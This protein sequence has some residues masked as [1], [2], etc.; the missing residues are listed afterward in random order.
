MTKTYQ[1]PSD[2]P[3][4][5]GPIEDIRP[6]DVIEHH[7]IDEYRAFMRAHKGIPDAK[8]WGLNEEWVD[9]K[10]RPFQIATKPQPEKSTQKQKNL[11][12]EKAQ[13]S[14]DNPFM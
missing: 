11:A 5:T 7:R 9:S 8:L 6:G 2:R 3:S 4:Y 1:H 12:H 14:P 10:Q 13:D